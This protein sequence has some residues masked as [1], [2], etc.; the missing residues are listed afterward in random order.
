MTEELK[1]LFKEINSEENVKKGILPN[2][3]TYSAYIDALLA[4]R[5]YSGTHDPS[6]EKECLLVYDLAKKKKLL[7]PNIY[8]SLMSIGRY[9]GEKYYKKFFDLAVTDDLAD[10]RIYILYINVM[11]NSGHPWEDIKKILFKNW[12]EYRK[13][14]PMS[15][16]SHAFMF[17]FIINSD[18]EYTL[19]KVI[20]ALIIE[21]RKEIQFLLF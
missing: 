9:F 1:E 4:Y 6:I 5:S 12:P 8:F 18:F 10:E 11:L 3:K 14:Q 2:S 17:D 21:R 19:H 16:G 15:I 20:I 13:I 7:N